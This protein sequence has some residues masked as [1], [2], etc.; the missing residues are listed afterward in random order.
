MLG[1]EDDAQY[2]V[3]RL[4][5]GA[6][7]DYAVVA[8]ARGE[9]ID[10]AVD[11]ADAVGIEFTFAGEDSVG[12]GGE[13]YV[14]VERRDKEPSPAVEEPQRQ[15][16]TAAA[17][18]ADD[19]GIVTVEDDDTR[20]TYL[21]FHTKPVAYDVV[22]RVVEQ[23]YKRREGAG[24]AAA[25]RAVVVAVY[26]SF[27]AGG[28]SHLAK[29]AEEHRA[30]MVV[31]VG[32]G[33]DV[34]QLVNDHVDDGGL[35]RAVGTGEAHRET[36]ARA[37]V[38]AHESA[39]KPTHIDYQQQ[40][41]A[42][43]VV[44]HGMNQQ[45]PFAGAVAYGCRRCAERAAQLVDDGLG[46]LG[47]GAGSGVFFRIGSSYGAVVEIFVKK[48]ALYVYMIEEAVERLVAEELVGRH[49]LYAEDRRIEEE[50]P[51]HKLRVEHGRVR[52]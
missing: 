9:E 7:V 52:R 22:D 2:L 14:V 24:A 16:D 13:K 8:G 5:G 34:A 4:G 30:E 6:I 42:A 35:A 41:A 12:V 36:G 44:T 50:V 3:D 21:R 46:M 18:V 33:K 47:G 51:L 49:E 31:G 29:V 48:L 26:L 32:L 27:H 10:L 25:V 43:Q 45:A 40:R 38:V 1:V 11:I 23:S 17:A 39:D 15:I 20:D 37:E 19:I 28:V